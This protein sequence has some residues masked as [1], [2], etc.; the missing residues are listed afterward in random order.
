MIVLSNGE[1]NIRFIRIFYE[2]MVP[3]AAKPSNTIFPALPA[4]Y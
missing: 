1:E 2:V 3:F 4:Y